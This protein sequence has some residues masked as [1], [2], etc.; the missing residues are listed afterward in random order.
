MGPKEGISKNK[1]SER[2][3]N[4]DRVSHKSLDYKKPKKKQEANQNEGQDMDLYTMVSEVNLVG[5]NT[6]KCWMVDQ[7]QCH[8]IC[9]L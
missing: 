5:S 8:H 7:Y 3:F 1:F 2:C 9:V 6:Q 4:H